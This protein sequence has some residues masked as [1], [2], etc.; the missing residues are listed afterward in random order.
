[1]A[2]GH[3]TLL[4]LWCCLLHGVFEEYVHLRKFTVIKVEERVIVS[5]SSDW[6]T[7][8]FLHST[9]SAR[10]LRGQASSLSGASAHCSMESQF[11]RYSVRMLHNPLHVAQSDCAISLPHSAVM[12]VSGH[13][14]V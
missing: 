1:M 6:C 14:T 2:T 9:L 4:N 7:H 8:V 5:R 10:F 11:P 12:N 13:I 3:H